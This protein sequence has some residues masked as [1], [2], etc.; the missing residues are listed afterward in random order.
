[1]KYINNLLVVTFVLSLLSLG[2]FAQKSAD[3]KSC[4]KKD[5]YWYKEKC[6]ENFE[7][8]GISEDKI[9]SYVDGQI[10]LINNASVFLNDAKFS[11]E[12][13]DIGIESEEGKQIVI[14]LAKLGNSDKTLL[15]IIDKK[16][17][18]TKKKFN[19]VS[20]LFAGDIEKLGDKLIEVSPKGE[21]SFNKKSEDEFVIEGEITDPKDGKKTKVIANLNEA[22]IGAGTSVLEIKGDEAFLSGD[23]GTITYKQIK[24]MLQKSPNVKTLVLT[25]ISGS[26]NDAVNM[27]TG[28]LVRRS[29]LNTKVLKDSKVYSG[30]VDLFAAGK[31][32]IVQEG[33]TLGVHSWCCVNDKTAIQIPKDHPAHQYQIAFFSEMMGAKNGVDFYFYTLKAA[34]FDNVHKMSKKEIL[35]WKLATKFIAR[36]TISKKE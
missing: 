12:K 2:V 9:E 23:L 28:R 25:N 1:M 22:V 19:A 18:D 35:D 14:L 20:I 33:A 16:D 5:G 31:E 4:E 17:F 11:I 34:P 26:I 30:G 27:H 15:N 7:D 10:K 8:E 29:G 21:L 36:E 3:K 6:W 13:T 24:D 32:R